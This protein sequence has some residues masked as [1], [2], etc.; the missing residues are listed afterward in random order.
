MHGSLLSAI[1]AVVGLGVGAQWLAWRFKLPSILLLLVFGFLAGPVTGLIDPVALQGDW[2]FPFV[3]LAVGIILFEG[4]LSLRL[5]EL[6]EVGKAVLNLVTV[7]VAITG[8]LAGLAAFYLLGFSPGMAVVIGSILT[9]TGPTVVIPL[10]RH[11][12][13][14]GRVGT[15]GK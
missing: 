7:G 1:A 3:S 9:V 6:R 8:V 11:V 15:I 10:L 13:P 2:L 5:D 4:G 14:S 12:R